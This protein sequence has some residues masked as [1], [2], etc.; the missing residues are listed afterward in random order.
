[1]QQPTIYITRDIERALGLNTSGYCIISNSTPFAKSLKQDNIL[2]IEEKEQLDTWQLLEHK[3]TKEFV[4]SQSI[5]VFKNTPQIER[6]CQKNN[7]KLLNPSAELSNKIEE[8]ISQ[9]DWLGDLKKYSPP[10]SVKPCKEIEFKQEP[11]IL[12]F[13]RSHTGAGTI[14]IEST[15]QLKKIQEKFGDYFSP[16]L[17]SL[18]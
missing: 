4:K 7:Y 10:Y 2:L 1:M 11:F 8:K 6:I 12:Q 14:L 3:Q 16:Y 5:L 9:L 17:K 18:I 13:N 15:E